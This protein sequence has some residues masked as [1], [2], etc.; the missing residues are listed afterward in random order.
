MELSTY[1][2]ASEDEL[3]QPCLCSCNIVAPESANIVP[4]ERNISLGNVAI[5]FIPM[6]SYV[7]LPFLS[8]LRKK[9]PTLFLNTVD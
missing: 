3:H 5:L 8:N 2:L 6:G 9:R 1:D 4:D 7:G